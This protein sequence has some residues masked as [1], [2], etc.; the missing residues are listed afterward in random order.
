[1]NNNV[2]HT[3]HCEQHMEEVTRTMYVCVGA[4]AC[5]CV[6]VCGMHFC[7]VF[8]E[9]SLTTAHLELFHVETL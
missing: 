2:L 3:W 5:M 9:E 6:Y 1:M 7:E 8:Y 4:C